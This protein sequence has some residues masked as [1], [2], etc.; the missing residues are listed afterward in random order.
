M[1]TIRN[2][3]LSVAAV[4]AT[5]MTMAQNGFNYQAVIR[6]NGEVV[7]NQDVTLRISIMNGDAI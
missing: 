6:N 3:M 7:S 5:T 4:L 1:S 2:L